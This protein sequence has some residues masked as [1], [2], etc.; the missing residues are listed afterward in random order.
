MTKDRSAAQVGAV[1]CQASRVSPSVS[2]WVGGSL[3]LRHRNRSD[4]DVVYRILDGFLTQSIGVVNY[5][6]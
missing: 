6:R 4:R 3:G 1:L 2:Q 5:V